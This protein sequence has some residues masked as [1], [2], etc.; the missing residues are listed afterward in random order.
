MV[1]SVN[2]ESGLNL[3]EDA[4][5]DFLLQQCRQRASGQSDQP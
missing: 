2:Q 1:A 3:D 4:V 5:V